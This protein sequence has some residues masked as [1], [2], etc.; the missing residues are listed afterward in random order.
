LR[1][2]ASVWAEPEAESNKGMEMLAAQ[3]N[4]D[5]KDIGTSM[6]HQSYDQ[7]S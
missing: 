1:S 6:H 4:L 5:A 2:G 7:T 3:K